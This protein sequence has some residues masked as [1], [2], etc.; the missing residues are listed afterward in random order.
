[1]T[2]THDWRGLLLKLATWRFW[3]SLR[4]S[5]RCPRS[6]DMKKN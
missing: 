3:H 1:M 2:T 5:G 6:T 4:F